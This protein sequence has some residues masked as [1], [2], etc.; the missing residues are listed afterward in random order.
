MML[1]SIDCSHDNLPGFFVHQGEHCFVP[2]PYEDTV[3]SLLQW[4]VY[5]DPYPFSS[6]WSQAAERGLR[7]RTPWARKSRL[8]VHCC[9]ITAAHGQIEMTFGWSALPLRRTLN[10][11]WDMQVKWLLQGKKAQ[12]PCPLIAHIHCYLDGTPNLHCIHAAPVRISS[13]FPSQFI[14]PPS[15]QFCKPGI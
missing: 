3:I 10:G 7:W 12:I 14:A 13:P 6:C 15:I 5:L 4:T 8:S 11:I 9:H 1:K 2:V